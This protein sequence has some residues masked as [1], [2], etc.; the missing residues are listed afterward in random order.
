LL[1]TN[2]SLD[3]TWCVPLHLTPFFTYSFLFFLE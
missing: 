3:A 1:S 2:R